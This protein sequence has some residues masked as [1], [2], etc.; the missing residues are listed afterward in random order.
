MR[1]RCVKCNTYYSVKHSR[2]TQL[3]SLRCPKD[4]GLLVYMTFTNGNELK[5]KYGFKWTFEGHLIPGQTVFIP[6]AGG[7]VL[8]TNTPT[9][10]NTKE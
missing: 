4:S 3:K 6:V 7:V 2:G 1:L 10:L 8:N 9:E 5:D